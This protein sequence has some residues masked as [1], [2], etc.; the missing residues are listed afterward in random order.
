MLKKVVVELA[1]RVLD[2]GDGNVAKGRRELG[3]NPSP[4]N[5]LVCVVACPEN[6]S[7]QCKGDN[8]SDVGRVKGTLCGMFCVV[9]ANMGMMER[10]AGGFGVHGQGVCGMLRWP[11]LDHGVDRIDE[12]VLGHRAE[13]A[14][15]VIVG[16][17]E[18]DV[19]GCLSE[20]AVEVAPKLWD[21]QL[22]WML[23]E[24]VL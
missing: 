5:L 24:K 17:V 2:Q 18:V 20:V 12:A 9:P 10:I 22:P 1:P 8:G 21:G 11:L 16:R 4:S 13:E 6:T 15:E 23:W 19:G 3:A 7:V 14:D